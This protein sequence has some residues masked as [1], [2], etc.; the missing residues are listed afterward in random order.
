MIM[1]S[2]SEKRIET[3]EKNQK[4]INNVNP[5]LIKNLKDLDYPSKNYTSKAIAK[6]WCDGV[7]K[8][9]E[10]IKNNEKT[11]DK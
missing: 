2:N 7:I 4:E 5:K 6:W 11:K 1:S 8:A 3:L 10:E 9:D